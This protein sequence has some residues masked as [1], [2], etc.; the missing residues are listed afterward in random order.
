MP[1]HA[2]WFVRWTTSRLAA[3]SCSQAWNFSVGHKLW[4]G[5]EG[6][7]WRQKEGR[8]ILK[9]KHHILSLNYFTEQMYLKITDLACTKGEKAL[10]SFS[11]AVFY[12]YSQPPKS[13]LKLSFLYSMPPELIQGD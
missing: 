11:L 12:Y 3:A 8:V 7:R 9:L 4:L 6:V 5:E 2:V 13:M 10:S 1:K